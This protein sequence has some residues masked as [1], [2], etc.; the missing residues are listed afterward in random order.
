MHKT[1]YLYSDAFGENCGA[2]EARL[3]DITS[4]FPFGCFGC[5][6]SFLIAAFVCK[7]YFIVL[8]KAPY[9]H[10]QLMSLSGSGH[11]LTCFLVI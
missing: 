10:L 4:Q 11:F 5:S 1:K 3:N 9:S 6:K 2:I 8:L 7:K